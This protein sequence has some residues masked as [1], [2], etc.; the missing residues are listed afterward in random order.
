MARNEF[1]IEAGDLLRKYFPIVHRI[2]DAA[3]NRNLGRQVSQK[4]FDYFGIANGGVTF[5]AEAKRIKV[6]RFAFNKLAEHQYDALDEYVTCGGM[7][8]FLINFRVKAPGQ[9]CGSAF[10]IP[11]R[12]YQDIVNSRRSI[13]RKSMRPEHVPHQYRLERVSGGWVFSEELQNYVH[14]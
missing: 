8:F 14:V 5:A 7:S 11:F 4:P 12:D 2:A 10:C 1:E 13:G 3:F 9:R 6:N